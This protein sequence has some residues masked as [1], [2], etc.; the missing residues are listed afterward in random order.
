M[1]A[2]CP[3]GCVE[4]VPSA[5]WGCAH[6][7]GCY[8]VGNVCQRALQCCA[9]APPPLRDTKRQ[10]GVYSASELGRMEM[11]FCFENTLTESRR[12]KSD[13]CRKTGW[14]VLCPSLRF[15]IVSSFRRASQERLL[16]HDADGGLK[17]ASP[18]VEGPHAS[19]FRV[20]A[21]GVSCGLSLL[22]SM[23]E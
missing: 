18:P 16:E 17:A 21:V 6:I 8:C 11:L 5:P 15:L 13:A 14:E 23:Q 3:A 10:Q 20:S 1:C 7:A 12:P 4:A 2:E 19:P 9:P 22:P